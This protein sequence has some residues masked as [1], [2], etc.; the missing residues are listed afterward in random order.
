MITG[1]LVHMK[2]DGDVLES[3]LGVVTGSLGDNNYKV[4]WLDDASSGTQGIYAGLSL[5]AMKDEQY[6]DTIF[7]DW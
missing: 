1:D 4:L 7:S 2:I 5:Q 3:T 6:E